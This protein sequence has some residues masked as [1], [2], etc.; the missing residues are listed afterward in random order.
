MFRSTHADLQQVFR[1]G[2]S[3]KGLHVARYDDNDE[4]PKFITTHLNERCYSS[5]NN[6]NT[7]ESA[8]DSGYLVKLDARTI[9]TAF[10]EAEK[11][12]AKN[13]IIQLQTGESKI[14]RTRKR[15]PTQEWTP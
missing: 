4:I 1:T 6:A 10:I 11:Y 2:R 7:I 13:C 15:T 8:I 14:R 9:K 5:D 12:E 3:I